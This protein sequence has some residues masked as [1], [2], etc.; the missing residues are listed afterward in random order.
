MKQRTYLVIAAGLFL[1]LVLVLVILPAK[2]LD[3]SSDEEPFKSMAMPPKTVYGSG[4]MDGGS[5]VVF[6]VDRLDIKYEITF[7]IDYDGIRNAHPTAY[8]GGN[9]GSKMV[10][11][12][13]PARAK[14]IAIRLLDD[15]GTEIYYRNMDSHDYTKR[16]RTSLSEPLWGAGYRVYRK[17]ENLFD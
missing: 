17:L 14:A 6:I 13:N 9:H 5:V 4:C 16:A 15:Y 8:F 3:L 11:S 7:P 1:L 10:P 2:P 12:K